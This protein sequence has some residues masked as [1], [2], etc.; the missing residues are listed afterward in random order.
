MRIM[1]LCKQHNNV[2]IYIYHISIIIIYLISII[3]TYIHNFPTIVIFVTA[4]AVRSNHYDPGT[5][6]PEGTN[7]ADRAS[8][9]IGSHSD[10]TG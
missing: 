8:C 6:L 1:Y 10:D 5:S 7:K 2:Y 9:R 4:A 3:Y